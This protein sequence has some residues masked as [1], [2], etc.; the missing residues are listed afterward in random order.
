MPEIAFMIFGLGFFIF[1]IWLVTSFDDRS[2]QRRIME[3]REFGDI[4]AKP[5]PRSKK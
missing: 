4:V 1:V 2:F 3:R 5:V